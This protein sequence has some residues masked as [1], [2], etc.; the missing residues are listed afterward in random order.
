MGST[1]GRR[2]PRPLYIVEGREGS[3]T[4][5]LAPYSPSVTPLLPACAWRSPAGILL[6]PPPRRRAAG[7]SS[8]SPSPLL[9]QE[10]GD[11]FPIVRVLNVEV[12]S[13]R[14][15][16]IGDL[17]HDEYDSINPVLLNA[18]AR[19]LQGYVDALLSPSLLDDSID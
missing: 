2:P 5:L 9:D 1:R 16:V 17:D 15:L 4:L 18:S 10:G 8:T 19:D 13:V 11:I 3:R 6:H 14:H 7:S 12:L